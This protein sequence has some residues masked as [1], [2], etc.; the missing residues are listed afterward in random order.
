MWP[1]FP[2]GNTLS[3]IPD[4]GG[5]SNVD[6]NTGKELLKYDYE[7]LRYIEAQTAN[8]LKANHF[9]GFPGP[10]TKYCWECTLPPREQ[11]TR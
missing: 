1:V 8:Q 9:K 3:K 7:N 2:K 6:F 5:I 4:D 11:S 10:A